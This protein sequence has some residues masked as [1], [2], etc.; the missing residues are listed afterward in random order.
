MAEATR[1]HK[2][3]RWGF[4][5]LVTGFEDTLVIG[6][7][8]EAHPEWGDEERTYNVYVRYNTAAK[9]SIPA[10]YDGVIL[11][12]TDAGMD[13]SVTHLVESGVELPWWWISGRRFDSPE[14]A[15]SGRGVLSCD[16]VSDVLPHSLT[17]AQ[18]RLDQ[19]QATE[20]SLR[21]HREQYAGR[22]T[23]RNPARA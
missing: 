4:K 11:S 13:R 1:Y 17:G 15:P 21:K 22:T 7:V 18:Q 2:G 23:H 20:E 6:G 9:G 8:R 14:K 10:D 19:I 12:L 16:C 3:Q 5:P